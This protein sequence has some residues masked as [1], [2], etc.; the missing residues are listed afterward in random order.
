MVNQRFYAKIST[1]RLLALAIAIT[2]TLQ[3]FNFL[4]LALLSTSV[5]SALLIHQCHPLP[6]AA[7]KIVTTKAIKDRVVV[8]AGTMEHML[9]ASSA[10]I[11]SISDAFD[12]GNI[13]HVA[14]TTNFAD[15]DDNSL[16]ESPG[17][18]E[19]SLKVKL[20]P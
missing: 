9:P 5:A 16:Q 11:I 7:K 13:E 1:R 10:P 20:D 17:I 3:L 12:G 8:L 15:A 18:V 4:S 19:V 2:N 14:T 6:T